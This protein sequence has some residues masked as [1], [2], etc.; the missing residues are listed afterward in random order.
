MSDDEENKEESMEESMDVNFIEFD[1][2]EYDEEDDNNFS[3]VNRIFNEVLL[4]YITSSRINRTSPHV[5]TSSYYTTRSIFIPQSVDMNFR[6]SSSVPERI[7]N[8]M[9]LL[10]DSFLDRII[11]RIVDPFE[12]ILNE[13]FIEK[14]SGGVEKINEEIEIDSF[15]YKNLEKKEK[16]CC[17]CLEDFSEEDD[18]SFSK[19]QHLF[20]T[21]CIKEWSTYRTTCPVCRK[22]FEEE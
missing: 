4:N 5:S 12:S 9:R 19:C 22:N 21:K 1:D 8:N 20:H 13:S 11:D 6:Y 10:N 7:S 2:V 17:I 3:S 18:V 16:D 15:K 14:S